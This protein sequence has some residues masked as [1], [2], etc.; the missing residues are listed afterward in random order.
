[1][2]GFFYPEF[3]PDSFVHPNSA[4]N[5][6]RQ[7]KKTFVGFWVP[8]SIQSKLEMS[9]PPAYCFM[10]V[11]PGEYQPIYALPDLYRHY[12]S[13]HQVGY[14]TVAQTIPTVCQDHTH[15]G[16]AAQ[17]GEQGVGGQGGG[18]AQVGE[19]TNNEEGDTHKDSCDDKQG[20]AVTEGYKDE[21]TNKEGPTDCICE[22]RIRMRR[23]SQSW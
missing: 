22:A 8:Q 19:Q 4:Y 23:S 17:L 6:Q 3:Q 14:N 16:D 9:K 1:M 2:Q 13:S 7:T 20:L 5:S 10:S 18:G 15:H 11:A 21:E 12:L